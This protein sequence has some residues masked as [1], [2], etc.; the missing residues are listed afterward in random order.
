MSAAVND[1]APERSR[2][3][4]RPLVVG[5]VA[6]EAGMLVVATVFLLVS[7]VSSD[8]DSPAAL[9]ALA[10]ISLG[11]GAGLAWCAGGVRAGLG[12]TRGPVLTWQLLQV[13]VGMPLCTTGAWWAGV[14][15]LAV[16]VVVG[17]LIAGQQVIPRSAER[18]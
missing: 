12:W 5:L 8:Q 3:W 1:S 11:L 6:L 2:S 7:A 4:P 15:L 18:Y 17:V 10:A 16:S 14:P 9:A 13:G